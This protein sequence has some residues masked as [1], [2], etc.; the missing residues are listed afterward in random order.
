MGTAPIPP[1]PKAASIRPSVR[2]P[3]E[4]LKQF[5]HCWH[6]SSPTIS[7]PMSGKRLIPRFSRTWAS[8]CQEGG[9]ATGVPRSRAAMMSSQ[10]TAT[11]FDLE[12]TSRPEGA[13][14]ASEAGSPKPQASARKAR[15]RPPLPTGRIAGKARWTSAPN[16][17]WRTFS[18][19]R[20]KTRTRSARVC[21]SRPRQRRRS[22]AA[23]RCDDKRG[24]DD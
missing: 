23:D 10:G 9:S 24:R 4:F 11:G 22:G 20:A 14:H 1:V 3:S 15:Q 5:S 19:S 7:W 6:G 21:V 2:A 16:P 12:R 8:D 17:S 13:A 18:R